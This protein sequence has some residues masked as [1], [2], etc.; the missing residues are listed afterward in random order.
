MLP[1]AR[2]RINDRVD[3]ITNL[4]LDFTI[5]LLIRDRSRATPLFKLSVEATARKLSAAG[6]AWVELV[7][8]QTA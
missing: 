8:D 3:S 7:L 2:S 4:K 5:H 1:K 6:L